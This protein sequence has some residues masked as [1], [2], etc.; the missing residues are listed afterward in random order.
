MEAMD[1][2]AV[3][4]NGDD[5]DEPMAVLE[6]AADPMEALDGE[7]EAAQLPVRADEFEQEAEREVEAS[8]G[9]DGAA[10]EEGKM[11]LVHQVRHQASHSSFC[12]AMA[13]R[14]VAVPPNYPY[15]PINQHKRKD[16]PARTY[17]FEL[18]PFQFVATSCIER[19]ESVLVSAHTSAGKTVVAEFAIATCLAEGR[20]VVYTIRSRRSRTRSTENSLRLSPM[21]AS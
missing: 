14:Q 4:G 1:S 11:K 10:A 9:L 16:P 18:D 13:D 5:D 7:T 17:K 15:V 3:G 20:R 12:L 19:N 8:K 6:K 21:S 2:A